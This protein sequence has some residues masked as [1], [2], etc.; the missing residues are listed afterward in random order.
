MAK[1]P[2]LQLDFDEERFAELL[3]E[4]KANNP[5]L[6]VVVRCK[7]CKKQ[8]TQECALFFGNYEVDGVLSG[9]WSSKAFS[10]NF[11]CADGKRKEE[12]E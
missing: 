11:Y 10:E 2:I 4:Y 6:T 5:D 8:K 7:D 9:V 3:D 12:S 1:A